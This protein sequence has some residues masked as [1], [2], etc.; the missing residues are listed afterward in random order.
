[1]IYGVWYKLRTVSMLELAPV[2]NRRPIN[3]PEIMITKQHKQ[4][5]HLE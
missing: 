1:M 4:R 5:C 3:C 2:K